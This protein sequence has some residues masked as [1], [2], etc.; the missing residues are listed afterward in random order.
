MVLSVKYGKPSFSG[1]LS[2][3]YYKGCTVQVTLPGRKKPVI[4]V[5]CP[6]ILTWKKTFLED[7]DFLKY[8]DITYIFK[9]N[10]KMERK[11]Y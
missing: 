8:K 11:V 4:Q 3:N 1:M 7:R 2:K 6:M 5:I 10:M 9:K